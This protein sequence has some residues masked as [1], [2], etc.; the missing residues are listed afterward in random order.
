MKVTSEERGREKLTHCAAVVRPFAVM[1]ARHPRGW[2][3]C[4]L[5]LMAVAALAG[6]TEPPAMSF[7]EPDK[8]PSP[9]PSLP[10][11]SV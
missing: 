10:H 7:D 6:L 3:C 4:V 5:V 9:P 11:S 1:V 2:L 8:G